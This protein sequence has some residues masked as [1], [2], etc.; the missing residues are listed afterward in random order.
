MIVSGEP[1]AAFLSQALGV[2]FCP[3]YVAVGTEIDGEIVNAVLL[4]C[5][6]GPSVHVSVAGSRLGRDFLAAIGDYVFNV[7]GCERA[8]MTTA[9]D[10]VAGYCE[11]LGGQREG[12]LRNHFGRGVDGI[13]VGILKDDFLLLHP[14]KR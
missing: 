12:L 3:P 13:I 9:S 4:N 5:F 11:R 8:T 2:S 7:L 14:R 1:V 10:K 6:E